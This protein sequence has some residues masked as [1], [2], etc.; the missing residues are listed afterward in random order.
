MAAE[1]SLGSTPDMDIGAVFGVTG[2]N[3]ER[4][5]LGACELNCHERREIT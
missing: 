3:G 5:G 4:S 1:Q 2:R